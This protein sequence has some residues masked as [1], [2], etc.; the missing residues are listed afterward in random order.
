MNPE[1]VLICP[2]PI[3]PLQQGVSIRFR[4]MAEELSR[5]WCVSLW[6]PNEDI[7]TNDRYD[8]RP[9]PAHGLRGQ[10]DGVRAVIVH[11]DASE[12]YL[13]EL[14]A[15]GLGGGPPLVVDLYD[16]FLVD[17]LPYARDLGDGIYARDLRLLLRQLAAGDLFLVSS[18][19]QRVFYA[20][21]LMG[22]RLFDPS[23]YDADPTLQH[24]LPI[25][26]FGVRPEAVVS[27]DA[28]PRWKGVRPGIGPNDRVLFFGGIYDWYDP[29]LLLDAVADLI[30]ELPHLRVVF[31]AN[32]NPGSTPQRM[33][34]RTRERARERGL[35]DRAVFFVPWFP[36]DERAAY[37]R[38]V[39]VAVC[40]HRPSLEAD[41]S[42]RTRV[43]DCLQA[44]LPVIATAGG[45][46]ASLLTAS[47][48]G[49][50]VPPGDVD[51]LRTAIRV[52][53]NDAARRARMGAAGADWVRRERSWTQTLD[54][55]IRFCADPRKRPRQ[56]PPLADEW[57]PRADAP[58]T[59]IGAQAD[60][61]PEV[62]VIV[63]THNR[64]RLLAEMLAALAAQE[65]APRFEVVV[66][67]DGS[68][69]D[70]AR[71]LR[72]GGGRGVRVLTQPHRGSA[73]ARNAGIRAARA[74]LIAFLGDDTVPEPGWLARHYAC[75]EAA[76]GDP[77]LAV[78]GHVAWHP[79][80][81]V[82]PF[83]QY[84]NE[85]GKQFG[86]SLIDDPRDLRSTSSTRPTPRCTGRPPARNCSTRAF[87]TRRGRT[88]NSRIA[89]SG[90][91]CG[92]TTKPRRASRTIIRRRLDGSCGGRSVSAIRP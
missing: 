91:G 24:L 59:R 88:R 56:A 14:E 23:M 25:A 77:M 62:S 65:R 76:G 75:H 57:S 74:R 22:A 5:H 21:L 48:A 43:L 39:D 60:V 90:A 44:G 12:R 3:R 58:M 49:W 37:L 78:I 42:L 18:E 27:A 66:V 13:H 28:S 31:S 1:V 82:T 67:D 54:P 87:R 79:R 35:I 84:L 6:T 8:V 33:F 45:D 50:L 17:H 47:G 11:G 38:D 4:E 85:Q 71:W 7:F 36:Y 20:G 80:V 2:E 26:P 70:T 32:P 53:A 52:L 29:E 68:R 46:T 81:K 10:L 89:S 30:D 34:D 51:A 83:L 63:P 72:D 15:A 19:R 9:F 64:R 92:S 40:L 16:P 73:A 61:E 41:L 55:L 69:D 86:Y